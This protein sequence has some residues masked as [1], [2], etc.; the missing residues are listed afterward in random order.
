[1]K[2]IV[3]RNRKR[4]RRILTISFSDCS[5]V[6]VLEIVISFSFFFLSFLV[7]SAFLHCALDYTLCFTPLFIFKLGFLIGM[8]FDDM[9]FK[10]TF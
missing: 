10:R 3:A 7:N 9:V 5:D 1:M 2:L 6:S 8:M 4:F